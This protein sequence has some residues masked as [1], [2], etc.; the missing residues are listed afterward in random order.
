MADED[1]EAVAGS[2]DHVGPGGRAGGELRAVRPA[3]CG[4]GDLGGVADADAAVG[5]G[6]VEILLLVALDGEHRTE[7]GIGAVGGDALEAGAPGFE[8]EIL[9]IGEG[10]VLGHVHGLGD[11]RADIGLDRG[12][13]LHVVAGGD[14]ERVAEGGRQRVGVAAAGLPE[15][16][17]VVLDGVF[18]HRA[19]ALALLAGVGPGE[20]GLDAVRGVVGESEADGAG[21]GDGEEMRV[22]QAVGADLGADVVGQA[23]RHA[24][25]E[26]LVGVEERE[27]ALFAGEARPRRGRRRR[28][29]GG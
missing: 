10:V 7:H 9:E 28:A 22:A 2:L 23:L 29:S 6:L 12:L 17:G 16:P 25:G 8:V 11:R 13:H 3:E 24:R 27:G 1:R 14:L 4:E 19:V 15:P 20:G 26:E 5:F 21:G 18:A